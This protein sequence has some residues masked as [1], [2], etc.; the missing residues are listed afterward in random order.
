MN[1]IRISESDD[2]FV[3]Y[4]KDRGMYRVSVFSDNHFE[5]EYWFDAYEDKEVDDRINKIIDK[6]GEL[7]LRFTIKMKTQRL[8]LSASNVEHLFDLLIDWIKEL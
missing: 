7:Q 8:H 5:D 1:L 4:D 6:L 3:D 2:F